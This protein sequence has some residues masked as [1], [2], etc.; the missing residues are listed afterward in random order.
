VL[1]QLRAR[2]VHF[3]GFNAA[4]HGT[5]PL[6]AGMSSSAALEVATAL[7]LRELF[8]FTV[9]ETGLAEAPRRDSIGRLPE[10]EWDQRMILARLCQAAESQFVGANVGLLDQISS[11][12]GKAGH[13]IQIDCRH[14]TVEHEPMAPGFAIV[15]CDSGVK[16]NLAS[17][18]YNELRGHCESAALTLGVP[19]LRSVSMEQL[20]AARS[21]LD[22]RDYACARHVVGENQ[23]VVLGERA[24]RAGEVEQFGQFLYESHASSRDWFKNSCPELDIL[25]DL[26]R[27]SPGCVGARLTGGGF[28]GATINLVRHHEVS[29]FVQAMRTGYAQRIGR[30]LEPMIC[31][32]GDGAR[33]IR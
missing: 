19:A 7:T 25:V 1:L 29:A 27:Q 33:R 5:I 31:Q 18:H 14:L 23:R 4:I 28:G 9:T 16:H 10:L 15:V 20:E 6:G 2:G 3:T 22:E 8:P 12:F 11:L 32:I 24:L 17:G 30:S 26:A 21:R 13:V